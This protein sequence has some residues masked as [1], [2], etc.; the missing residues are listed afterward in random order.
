M[1]KINAIRK[2]IE[3]LSEDEYV[4]LRQW[5][6]ERDWK[7]W[8]QE[9]EEHSKSGKLD[10]LVREAFDQKRQRKLKDL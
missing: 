1:S 5:F 8:D 10:F 6:S 9:I 7:K 3:T 4:E 2:A